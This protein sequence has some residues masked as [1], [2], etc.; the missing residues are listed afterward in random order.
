MN[1]EEKY[2]DYSLE[3]GKTLNKDLK[4]TDGGKPL[5][6]IITAY[7]NCK[8]YIRQTANSVL[9][10]TFPFWEWIIVNDGSTEEGTDD[11]L[12]ELQ[13]DSR[14][15]VYNQENQGRLVARDNAISKTTADI[16]FMLDSDDVLD[17]TLIECRLLDVKNKSRCIMGILQLCQF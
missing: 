3:P 10:Q 16:I 14:I 15:K 11:I 1:E 2:F 4:Q 5:I 8:E 7:Y 12:N 13:K 6:S 9:N 17:P